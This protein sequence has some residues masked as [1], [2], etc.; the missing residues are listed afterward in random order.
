MRR[1]TVS[2]DNVLEHALDEAPARLGVGVGTA[3][4]EKLRAYARIGYEHTLEG[5]LEE[6]RLATYRAWAD[7]PEM[8]A[9]ARA[10]SR[11]AAS[12]GIFEDA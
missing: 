2:I 9:F 8:G 6:A 5:E 7:E 3:D 1:I 4:S 10:A 11:R 12:R